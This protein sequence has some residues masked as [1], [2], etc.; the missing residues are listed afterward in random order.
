MGLRGLCG[1]E[2]L[3]SHA[4]KM[5]FVVGR[6]ACVGVEGLCGPDKSTFLI[7]SG[8]IVLDQPETK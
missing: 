2:A 3:K 6:I 8:P 4:R 1:S 7:V 5:M